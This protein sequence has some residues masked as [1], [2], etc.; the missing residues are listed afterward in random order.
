MILKVSPELKIAVSPFFF[1]QRRHAAQLR[2]RTSGAF[3]PS[4]VTTRLSLKLLQNTLNQF[5]CRRLLDVGCGCGIF[6]LAAAYLGVPSVVGLDIDPRAVRL[7]RSNARANQLDAASQWLVGTLAAVRGPFDCVVAN[8][9][10]V[11]LM[12][13]V[14]DL[15]R[16]LDAPGR[17][18]VSGFQ[19]VDWAAVGALLQE[20][21]LRVAA[22]HSGDF[23]FYG[24]PPT[25]S[26]TWMAVLAHKDQGVWVENCRSK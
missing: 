2:V 4:H 19:D 26:F 15:C 24:T 17:L 21:R 10:G 25:G 13:V 9:P 14:E 5:P 12:D 11:V 7:A 8:L 22:I 18:I 1:W 23:T 20:Q 3:H 6:A 16:V